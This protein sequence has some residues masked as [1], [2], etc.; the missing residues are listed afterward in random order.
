MTSNVRS[1]VTL[2]AIFG[3]FVL[4][5]AGAEATDSAIFGALLAALVIVVFV[6][7][8]WPSMGRKTFDNG[9]GGGMSRRT[10]LIASTVLL[11]VVG[12]WAALAGHLEAV[13]PPLILFIL[14]AIRY[15]KTAV[16]R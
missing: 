9:G 5:G 1:I 12:I 10:S 15:R 3:A 16:D 6:I 7:F 14:V 8:V 11:V 4:G 2:T 13:I